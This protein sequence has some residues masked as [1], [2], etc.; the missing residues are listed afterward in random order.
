MPRMNVTLGSAPEADFAACRRTYFDV[1][2]LRGGN[3]NRASPGIGQREK[4]AFVD[5]RRYGFGDRLRSLVAFDRYLSGCIDDSD[6]DLHR[7]HPF[8]RLFVLR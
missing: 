5:R 3:Q 2:D 8:P 6:L 1:R 4:R 7:C